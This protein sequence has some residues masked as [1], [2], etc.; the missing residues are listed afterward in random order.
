MFALQ[1]QQNQEQLTHMMGLVERQMQQMNVITSVL[2]KTVGALH[3]D[4][5]EATKDAAQQPS[6]GG[7]RKDDKPA[8]VMGDQPSPVREE[9]QREAEAARARAASE[10]EQQRRAEP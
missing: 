2:Q 6:R 5:N 4:V 7:H 3:V 9:A 10:A 8:P 1:H